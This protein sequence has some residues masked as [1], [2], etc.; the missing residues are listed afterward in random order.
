MF[1]A[2]SVRF[3]GMAAKNVMSKTS[4]RQPEAIC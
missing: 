4:R 3:S 2:G 1:D